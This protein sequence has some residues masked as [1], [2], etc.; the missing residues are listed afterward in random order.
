[1]NGMTHVCL[2]ERSDDKYDHHGP[3]FSFF[4]H[5]S[6]I[7]NLSCCSS[8]SSSSPSQLSATYLHKTRQ[9]QIVR[10]DKLEGE[11]VELR[12]ECDRSFASLSLI[13]QLAIFVMMWCG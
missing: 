2:C 5:C 11:R 10:N 3:S 9:L 7:F 4:L 6:G 13:N 12:I 8:S 1:M